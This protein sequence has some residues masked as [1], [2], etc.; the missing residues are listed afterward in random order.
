MQ[1]LL[2]IKFVIHTVKI[3]IKKMSV[4][5]LKYLNSNYYLTWI[6]GY[7][8]YLKTLKLTLLINTFLLLLFTTLIIKGII[9]SNKI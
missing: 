3:F 7:F 1:L 8:F 2:T 9:T 4:L 6:Y 5:I